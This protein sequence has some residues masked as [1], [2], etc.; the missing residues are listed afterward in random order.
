[1]M[2]LGAPPHY[3]ASYGAADATITGRNGQD[4]KAVPREGDDTVSHLPCSALI[5][6]ALVSFAMNYEEKSPVALSLSTT[7]IKRIPR[8]GR[9]LQGL[10]FSVG[11]AALERHGFVLVSGAEG[12][13]TVHLTPEGRAVSDTYDER[14]RT[15]ETEWR[16]AFGDKL[17][18][19]LRLALTV[20]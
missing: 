13:E 18:T 9:P 5:S 12:N 20:C 2:P 14:V 8:E 17:V 16:N 6:E 11:V 1:M 3:P 10:G 19:A 15:V 7:V 4:W